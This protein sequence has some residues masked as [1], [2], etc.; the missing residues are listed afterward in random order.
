M[1]DTIFKNKKYPINN[2]LCNNSLFFILEKFLSENIEVD[3]TLLNKI[4]EKIINKEGLVKIV[5]FKNIY[6]NIKKEQQSS[7]TKSD[8]NTSKE[9]EEIQGEN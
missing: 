9:P 7:I 6:E 8:K 2:V 4:V 1:I 5:K 3:V